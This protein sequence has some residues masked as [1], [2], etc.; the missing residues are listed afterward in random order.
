[1]NELNFEAIFIDSF[2]TFKIFDN[3]KLDEVNKVTAD[4]PKTVWQI[5]NHLI[6]WQKN[7]LGILLDEHQQY[8][9]KEIETWTIDHAEE[10][11]HIAAAVSTFNNQIANIKAVIATLNLDTA[12]I[13]SKLKCVQDMTSHLSFHLG[14]II[15]IRRQ[16]KNYPLPHE[17]NSFLAG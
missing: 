5:L 14:E 15:L 2:D 16:M 3:L 12:N 4:T 11:H 7:Q 8:D 10:Q 13:Q 1:M 6:I 9:I 17:M